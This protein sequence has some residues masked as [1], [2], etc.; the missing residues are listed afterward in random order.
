MVIEIERKFLVDKRKMHTLDF[1]SEEKIAQ[2]YLSN[3]PTIRVRLTDN[4][5]FLTI[6]SSIRGFARQEFEYEIPTSDAEKLLR[7]CGRNVLRKY[8]R[9]IEY[10]GHVWEVDFFM[11]RHAG[12]VLAEVELNSADEIVALPDWVTREVTGDSRYY[13]SNI[14]KS[15]REALGLKKKIPN[16]SFPIP[17]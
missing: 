4:R 13:N 15:D 5:A 17:N 6:K 12:L 2:G 9:K 3:N 7:L 8:R 11:G 1:S 14:V 16:S 10:A